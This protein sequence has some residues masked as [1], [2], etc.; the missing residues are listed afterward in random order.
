VLRG[1]LAAA[2]GLW[3]QLVAIP[4][5]SLLHLDLAH[6]HPLPP[7][8]SSHPRAHAPPPLPASAATR[9]G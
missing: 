6:Q 8:P 4:G 3:G 2:A 9:P 5:F 1:R 7:P